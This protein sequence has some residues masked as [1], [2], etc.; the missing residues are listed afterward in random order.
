[1]TKIVRSQFLDNLHGFGKESSFL[2]VSKTSSV[3][4]LHSL[5]GFVWETKR[6]VVL[7]CERI[8][9]ENI[10]TSLSSCGHTNH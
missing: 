4:L 8:M 2:D 9:M 1:M 6:H 7:P 10:I 5:K 3:F